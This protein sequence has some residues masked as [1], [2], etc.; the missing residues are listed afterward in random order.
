MLLVES[1]AATILSR[2]PRGRSAGR[3]P[4]AA[5]S[6]AARA[7]VPGSPTRHA[8]L[9]RSAAAARASEILLE[10]GADRVPPRDELVGVRR[11]VAAAAAQGEQGEEGGAANASPR[12]RMPV[13][14]R[15]PSPASLPRRAEQIGDV[16]ELLL[17]VAPIALEAL[18]D[19][20]AL[21]PALAQA[22]S[23]S[24]GDVGVRHGHLPLPM[25]SMS[26]SIRSRARERAR[27]TLERARPVP[28]IA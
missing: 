22:G 11:V 9:F 1:T 13:S 15:L 24:R 23:L 26:S 20:V 6:R 19:V 4:R 17:E 27:P 12:P 2:C 16:R 28:V 8:A 21:V 10:T 5:R 14:K 25:R 3:A 7:P 18:E